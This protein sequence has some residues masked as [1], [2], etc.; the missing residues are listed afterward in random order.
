VVALAA[1]LAGAPAASASSTQVTF[2]EAPPQLLSATARPG[3]ITQMQSLG[4]RAVRIVLAWDSVTPSPNAA[5]MPAD[6]VATD[7][8][9]YNWG[10]YLP[11]VTAAQAAGFQVLL[12]VAGPAPRWA[13]SSGH[14]TNPSAT[15]YGQFMQAV[16][17]EFGSTVKLYSIWNEPNQPQFLLPQ[18]VHGKLKSA[19]IYRGL[20]M[21][22][23]AGLEA[24][25]NFAGMTV[26][27]GETSPVGVK[28]SG[29]PAPLAFLRGV[30][31]LNA[32]Y[33][34]VG[35]CSELQLGGWAQH[36]YAEK[37]GPFWV[38]TN[39]DDVS[40]GTLGRLVTALNRAASAGAIPADVPVYITEFGVISRPNPDI[41]VSVARQA[42]FLSISER[43]AWQ[44]PRVASYAQYLLTDA[45]PIAGNPLIRWT[46]FQSGLEYLNGRAKPSYNGWRLPLTVTWRGLKTASFWG[47]VRPATAATSV[48]LEYSTN[49]G[50]TWMQQAVVNTDAS[51]YWTATSSFARNRVWRVEWTSPDATV[52]DGATTRAYTPSGRTV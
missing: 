32:H 48:T 16:G 4:V 45:P 46:S 7:P 38:P 2:F 47:L 22:G 44:N 43:L 11:A 40:I 51:G 49:G 33:V 34:K 52:Y 1:A 28:A 36:P 6:F 26:L 41:G 15:D 17:A 24:S 12:T 19:A 21:A 5:T 18:Y 27:M 30:L 37:Q 14:V 23:Y 20:Y 39:H 31:C 29:I 10:Q 3:A 42:E 13:T 50:A 25:G 35:N 8:T 9:Q